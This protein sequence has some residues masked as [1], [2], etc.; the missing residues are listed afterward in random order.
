MA[1]IKLP[2]PQIS[3]HII[4][5]P[6]IFKISK[7]GPTASKRRDANLEDVC[8]SSKEVLRRRGFGQADSFLA[9]SQFQKGK[10]AHGSRTTPHRLQ[11]M[12]ITNSYYSLLYLL[13]HTR[14]ASY[15]IK[16]SISTIYNNAGI[17]IC[18]PTSWTQ[19]RPQVE[20]NVQT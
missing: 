8:R 6:N 9:A 2:S 3:Q 16:S 17:H 20:L 19:R 5:L 7:Y 14:F 13:I 11:G 12:Q 18:E 4:S 15:L 10:R 1:A